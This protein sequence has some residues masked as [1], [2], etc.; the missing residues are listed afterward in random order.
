[1]IR[2]CDRLNSRTVVHLLLSRSFGGSASCIGPLSTRQ[3]LHLVVSSAV[4]YS[5]S[6]GILK[7]SD[8]KFILNFNF[9]RRNSGILLKDFNIDRNS[10][11]LL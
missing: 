1:M 3:I 8:F 4:D 11:D 10:K 6:T 9:T 2:S 5:T 7:Q